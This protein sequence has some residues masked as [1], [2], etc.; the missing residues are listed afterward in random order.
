M[1]AE[2]GAIV[3]RLLPEESPWEARLLLDLAPL[4]DVQNKH[5]IRLFSTTYVNYAWLPQGASPSSQENL[6]RLANFLFAKN[7]AIAM[8][9]FTA[10]FL[11]TGKHP[12]RFANS[13]QFAEYDSRYDS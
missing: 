7:S 3:V 13:A 11:Q 12:L 4:P 10:Q 1:Y 5:R 2:I 8:D 6:R 9:S